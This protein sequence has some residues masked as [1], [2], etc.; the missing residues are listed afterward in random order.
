VVF[1][2]SMAR[3]EEGPASDVDVFVLAHEL[4]ENPFDRQMFLRGPL[5]KGLGGV[6][7]VAKTRREFEGGFC[8]CIYHRWYSS[9]RYRR[10]YEG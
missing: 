2:G 1:F 4:P 7:I 8:S 10:L 3:G 6:S 5:P 9:V